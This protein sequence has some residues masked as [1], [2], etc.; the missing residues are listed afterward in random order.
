M[1]YTKGQ[2]CHTSKKQPELLSQVNTVK[3]MQM[4]LPNQAD[5][6]GKLTVYF[7]FQPMP[8]VYHKNT[9]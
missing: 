7:L 1:K 6:D 5:I 2:I 9:Y 8:F 4:F 3:L